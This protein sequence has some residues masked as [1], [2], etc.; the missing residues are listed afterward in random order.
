MVIR[1]AEPSEGKLKA[2]GTV[3][4]TASVWEAGPSWAINEHGSATR[5]EPLVAGL[6]FD[7]TLRAV[8]QHATLKA[9]ARSPAPGP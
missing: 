6:E 2:A 5:D 4:A 9:P 8:A 3:K 1:F 7:A